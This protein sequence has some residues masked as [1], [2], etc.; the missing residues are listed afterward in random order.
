[1]N[2]L[3]V[4]DAA[5]NR[6][7]QPYTE[8]VTLAEMLRQN[9]SG[10]IYLCFHGTDVSEE[11]ERA[12]SNTGCEVIGL[13]SEHLRYHNPEAMKEIIPLLA[14]EFEC[15]YICLPHSIY[16]CQVAAATAVRL[17]ASCITSVESLSQQG[18][19]TVFC[20]SIFNGKITVKLLP[21]TGRKVLTMLP[22]AFPGHEHTGSGGS[23][24]VRDIEADTSSYS[25]TGVSTQAAA[26]SSL[27][28]ADVIISAGRGIGKMENIRILQEFARIFS[29]SAIGA[30][31]I[32]CDNDWLPYSRQVGITGKT[33]APGLYVAC[34]ISGSQQHISGMKGSRCIISI[35]IDPDASIFS[36][37]DFCIVE[38]LTTFIPLVIE[39]YHKNCKSDKKH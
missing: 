1:M 28:E 29:G 36:V 5:D 12:A 20:R 37:S 4:A 14:E 30:S 27:D 32:V 39:K 16:S 34:G 33:V 15:E 25:T 11:A 2:I 31:R 19:D 8:L 35:N 26:D 22:G 7:L 21:C 3:I 13:Q 24:T 17:N 10:R 18:Q 38:D 6:L 9:S 23:C